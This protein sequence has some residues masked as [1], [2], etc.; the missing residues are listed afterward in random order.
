VLTDGGIKNDEEMEAKMKN[1][2]VGKEPEVMEMGAQPPTQQNVRM[3]VLVR[4]QFAQPL[5]RTK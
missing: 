1:N 2:L 3:F 5:M 4:R